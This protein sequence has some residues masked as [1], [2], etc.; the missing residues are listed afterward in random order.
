MSHAFHTRQSQR[1]G[2]LKVHNKQVFTFRRSAD[3]ENAI[4]EFVRNFGIQVYL[5]R[6]FLGG[7]TGVTRLAATSEFHHNVPLRKWL[8]NLWRLEVPHSHEWVPCTANSEI[9]LKAVNASDYRYIMAASIMNSPTR[10]IFFKPRRVWPG[11]VELTAHPNALRKAGPNLN[12]G[13]YLTAHSKVFHDALV[14]AIGQADSPL[15]LV[16][17]M[18]V[19]FRDHCW[20]GVFPVNGLL[21]AQMWTDYDL[22]NAL[23]GWTRYSIGGRPPLISGVVQAAWTSVDNSFRTWSRTI[24]HAR[25]F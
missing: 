22:R 18:R 10:H 24:R 11:P 13:P 1:R 20:D 4:R 7:I 12:P 17:R 25:R 8:S 15:D 9:I 16:D 6:W 21:P 19:V 2:I 23:G 3:R 14:D 5:R